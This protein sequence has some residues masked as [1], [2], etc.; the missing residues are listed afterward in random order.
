MVKRATL[1][2]VFVVILLSFPSLTCSQLGQGDNGAREEP[3]QEGNR[4]I[5][6]DPWPMFGQ[7]PQHTSSSTFHISG[8]SLNTV[9]SKYL[10]CSAG[11]T[12]VIDRNG[13]VYIGT[14]SRHLITTECGKPGLYAFL[15]DGT[16]IWNLDLKKGTSST[17]ALGLDNS[18]YFGSMDGI[19]YALFPNGTIKWKY[20]T[21]GTFSSSPVIG[22]NGT[23]YVVSTNGYLYAFSPG[24]S[25]LW[26]FLIGEKTT[27]SPV[28][29]QNGLIYALSED[30]NFWGFD[31]S[32]VNSF[33]RVLQTWPS[34]SPVIDKNG[35]IYFGDS[36][37]NL[38]SLYKDGMT[39]WKIPIG[40]RV[41]STPA[42]GPDGTIYAVDS[43]GPKLVAILNEILW[44]CPLDRDFD[45]GSSSI[46][47][48]GEGII[49]VGGGLNNDNPL[50]EIQ[51]DG[52]FLNGKD[53]DCAPSPSIDIDG[54]LYFMMDGTM[55]ALGSPKTAPSSPLDLVATGNANSVAL[56][57]SPPSKNGGWDIKQYRIYRG[58][59]KENLSFLDF[60]DSAVT[61]FV[62]KSVVNGTIY[63]YYVTATNKRGESDPSNTVSLHIPQVYG[64]STPSVT[65]LEPKYRSLQSKTKVTFLGTASDDDPNMTV[66]ISSDGVL[67]YNA[68]GT[69]N[70]SCIHD[71]PEGSD[72][73]FVKAI[74]SD[75][76]TNTLTSVV[77][78]DLTPPIVEITSPG[79]NIWVTSS[80]LDLTGYADDFFGVALVEVGTDGD[81]WSRLAGKS[82]WFAS[83]YIFPPK[84]T[85]YIRATDMADNSMTVNITVFVDRSPP[86]I[87]ITGPLEGEF[88]AG[89]KVTVSGTTTDNVG[90]RTVEVW[91]GQAS[92]LV[93]NG[94]SFWSVKCPLSAGYNTI[95]AKATDLAGN[96]ALQKVN[97]TVDTEIPAI[98]IFDSPS[99]E[100]L[101]S[102]SL[103]LSGRVVD[104]IGVSRVELSLD[105]INWTQAQGLED[106]TF[107]LTLP[108]GKDTIRLRAT[109]LAGNIGLENISVSVDSTPPHILITEPKD[110]EVTTDSELLLFGNISDTGDMDSIWICVNDQD[111]SQAAGKYQWAQSVHLKNGKNI[112]QI[113]ARDMAGNTNITTITITLKVP[114]PSNNIS[115]NPFYMI[116][117]VVLIF[118]TMMI[119]AFLYLLRSTPKTVIK[120]SKT[121]QQRSKDARKRPKKK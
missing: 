70:W 15:R 33:E 47:V 37:G 91:A 84:T 34:T 57:W 25:L 103:R 117:I 50:Q 75:G 13:T 42:I 104:N 100:Y 39:R 23:I 45:S 115:T 1:L 121:V 113:K 11:T 74:D 26:N 3:T 51:S 8:N 76:N 89:M 30:G 43:G 85:I 69:S 112:I 119:I 5:T 59:S 99:H 111:W 96:T 86:S 68:T 12:P 20:T 116:G 66:K 44:T 41:S 67:W 48:S 21:N 14:W 6:M 114:R 72:L 28:I 58:T 35:M 80:I 83:V 31:E 2:S 53:I 10:G 38:W 19:F 118:I 65:L 92:P 81:N 7:N 4:A 18:L 40:G 109:D 78:I 64:A 16:Y 105:G 95:Y 54:T 106:W 36:S 29:G 93:I 55:V 17:P 63:F 82:T 102:R 61:G 56:N 46:T 32:G 98:L 77:L 49:L 24:G 60:T 107:N 87:R 110:G 94:T 73:F 108:E 22:N 97:V 90:V 71:L 101:A 52:Y 27:F 120:R 88:L 79:N 9:W 62:D